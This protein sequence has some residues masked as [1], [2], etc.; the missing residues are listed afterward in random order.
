MK[1]I[2]KYLLETAFICLMLR[3]LILGT[4]IGES[5]AAVSLVASLAYKAW[6]N[7]TQID[8]LAEINKKYEELA[9]VVQSLQMDK[10]VRRSVSEQKVKVP[11]TD[12]RF[13]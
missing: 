6:L 7:K 1:Y 3:M 10:A 13:F 11:G 2:E 9:T 4:G 8:E 12:K 5:I